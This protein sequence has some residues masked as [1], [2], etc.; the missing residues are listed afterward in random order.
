MTLREVGAPSAVKSSGKSHRGSRHVSA[1]ASAVILLVD[2]RTDAGAVENAASSDLAK[3]PANDDAGDSPWFCSHGI[4]WERCKS[5]LPSEQAALGRFLSGLQSTNVP[6]PGTLVGR[7][8]VMSGGQGHVLQALA[9]LEVIRNIH[10]SEL[11]VE[12]WHAFELSEAH[13]DALAK[14]G[15]TCH[16][17]LMPGVYPQWETVMPAIMSSSFRE[18]L[19]IDTDITPLVKP[20]LLFETKAYREEGALFWPDLWAMGCDQWGQTAWPVH[21]AWHLLDM[22]FNAS[23]YHCNQEHEAGHLLIDKERHWRPLCLANYLASRDFFTRVLHGYKDVFRL[24]WL[25]LQAPNRLTPIRPGLVGALLPNGQFFGPC[26]IHFWPPDGDFGTFDQ[27]RPVPLY[28]HQ[29]KIPGNLWQEV[30][31]FREPLGECTKY[32]LTPFLPE[33]AGADVWGIGHWHFDFAVKLQQIDQ[34]WNDGYWAGLRVL[35]E[36]PRLE[37]KEVERLHALR[38]TKRTQEFQQT[39]YA[40]RC[41]Y[42]DNRWIS[43]LSTIKND[44]LLP[45]PLRG[46]CSYILTPDISTEVC[47]VGFAT[48]ALLCSQAWLRIG[49]T[50]EAKVAAGLLQRILPRIKDCLPHSFWPVSYPSFQEYVS[51]LSNDLRF[52]GT[53]EIPRE[54]ITHFPRHLRRS[55]PF[56]DPQCWTYVRE[57]WQ[58]DCP[59]HLTAL[60]CCDPNLNGY[61]WKKECFDEEFTEKRCCNVHEE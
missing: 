8:I 6:R 46:S 35:Q 5:Y 32:R 51:N 15:A 26:L 19:W 47:E 36:D 23:D 53:I 55:V 41:N 9:N 21:I 54:R 56:P 43:L 20:D 18:A 37:K 1:V 24:A 61:E 60:Y 3:E 33:A 16:S 12:F 45:L 42:A 59:P 17:L 34:V 13:C 14:M 29:K 52:R 22:E 30:V 7:G 27:G 10:G 38:N 50:E 40:C 48:L 31:T 4:P 49:R 11:P 58:P 57:D 44:F 39:V 25:K 28:I 2:A